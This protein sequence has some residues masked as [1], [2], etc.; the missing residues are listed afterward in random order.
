M[1]ATRIG[2]FLPLYFLA[3]SYVGRLGLL[4]GSL[5]SS[6]GPG[7][8]VG[9]VPVCIGLALWIE[10]FGCVGVSLAEL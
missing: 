7:M 1:D 3:S 2:E 6:I 9:K 8:G 4:K 10:G 5:G